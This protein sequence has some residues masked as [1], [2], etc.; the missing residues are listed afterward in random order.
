MATTKKQT[1]TAKGVAALKP[2][3]WA[4]DTWARGE[5]QFQARGLA[6]GGTGYYFRYTRQDGSSVR[7]SVG[8]NLPLAKARDIAKDLSRRY[9]QAGGKD[10]REI[11]EAEQ[12]ESRRQDDAAKQAEQDKAGSTLGVL[13]MTYCDELEAAK[14]VSHRLVRG[15][16]ILHVKEAWPTLWSTPA[17]D[18]TEDDMV[19]IVGRVAE[20]KGKN[21][22]LKL[23]TA[24]RIRSYLRAAYSAAIRARQSPQASQALRA[25][26]IRHNPASDVAAIEGASVPRERALSLSELRCYWARISALSGA[27]GA[28]LRFHL[29]SGGQRVAQLA[30]LTATDLDADTQT[31]R[32]MD[33]KGRRKTKRQ[34]DVP[35]I[36]AAQQ[37]LAMMRGDKPV[38]DK[39]FTLTQGAGAISYESLRDWLVVVRDEMEKAGELEKGMFTIGDLR[40]SVETR[41]A[42]DGISQEVRGQLQSHG[43]GNV[44]SRHYDRHRYLGEKRAALESL[45]RLLTGESATVTPIKRKRAK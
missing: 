20:L 18:V 37:A 3:E 26:G 13:L 5:G 7:I 30:R 43:L 11:L 22:K 12:R 36:P 17:T 10:L 8:V 1:M 21:G 6:G 38:G 34:H 19:A 14:K 45:F 24:A 44:Q 29:L 31:V 28:A 25:L 16:L 23:R 15:A 4:T 42:A 33:G 32:L 40:R 41:L 9:Q 2:G 39:L 35:L 27:P